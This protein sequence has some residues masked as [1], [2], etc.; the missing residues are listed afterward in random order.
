MG[1][2]RHLSPFSV[3]G[4]ASRVSFAPGRW[5]TVI[6]ALA[7]IAGLNVAG[8]APAVA[9]HDPSVGGQGIPPQVATP[10]N[11][12]N[13]SLA[14]ILVPQAIAD[15]GVVTFQDD[16][17]SLVSG[18]SVDL[19]QSL[20]LAFST[21]GDLA[22]RISACGPD[23][24]VTNFDVNF[25]HRNL[26]MGALFAGIRNLPKT[27]A[28]VLNGC[29]TDSN[30]PCKINDRL[31]WVALR[32]Y[33][34]I[35]SPGALELFEG[36]ITADSILA[37]LLLHG[38]F[39]QSTLDLTQQGPGETVQFQSL[40]QV[41]DVG[42]IT[43]GGA[44]AVFRAGKPV[45]RGLAVVTGDGEVTYTPDPNYHG[46]DSFTYSTCDP[47]DAC[48]TAVVTVTVIP[49]MISRSRLPTIT[50]SPRTPICAGSTQRWGTCASALVT[51]TIA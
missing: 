35:H 38:Q 20:C 28:E 9:T 29:L 4:W 42:P 39:S 43:I 6:I 41:V 14:F 51:L 16:I 25:G 26:T 40:A 32:N 31:D 11:Q 19:A 34:R 8:A 49:V 18:A 12:S 24:N 45:D 33:V 23:L 36:D 10:Q 22:S 15:T 37:V 17:D 47:D 27:R 5:A 21:T 48:D 13:P 46:L 3:T 30:L 1:P 2:H 7:L 44:D 50:R